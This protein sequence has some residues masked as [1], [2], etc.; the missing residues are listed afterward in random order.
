M[1]GK[2]ATALA[3]TVE[4]IPDPAFLK[5]LVFGLVLTSLTLAAA[6]IGAQNAVDQFYNTDMGWLNV[7]RD[8][9]IGLAVLWV[10]FLL[11]VPI[12]AIYV[13]IFL[14]D[15]VDAV[16]NRY[17]PER[18]GSR[19]LGLGLASWLGVRL[20]VYVLFFN[21]LALPIYIITL[22]IPFMP[23]LIFYGL[24]SYLLGWG[25]YEMVAVRHLGMK[26]S[27]TH[28]KS[29]RGRILAAGLVTTFMFTIP[30]LNLLAPILGTAL[31]VH[32]FHF[33]TPGAL[34]SP[35]LPTI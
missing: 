1:A 18:A 15:V 7:V 17:Y 24:N 27:G 21:I 26:E 5:V 10:G 31:L 3:R 30:V 2:F 4:Q 14:D 28:R 8:F 16:E 32:L 6:A 20:G 35:D 25:Y 11:F 13:G 34:K 23:M 33:S 19:R 29:I 22:W 9:A 12:S